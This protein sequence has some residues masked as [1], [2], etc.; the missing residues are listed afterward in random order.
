MGR[1]LTYDKIDETEIKGLPV[2]K[3]EFTDTKSWMTIIPEQDHDR[4]RIL[5]VES[6]RRG[7][8]RSMLDNLTA[9]LQ[10]TTLR[11]MT[12][13]NSELEGRLQGFTKGVEVPDVGP[14]EGESVEYLEGEWNRDLREATTT[15][16]DP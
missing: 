5:M 13:L 3:A 10:S 15:Q 4:I 12:P 8:M 2:I 1:Q 9:Q 6:R 14:Y 7:D 11:F 16:S